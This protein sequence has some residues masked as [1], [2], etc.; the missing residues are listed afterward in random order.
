SEFLVLL[1][2]HAAQRRAGTAE[3]TPAFRCR[4]ARWL[5]FLFASWPLAEVNQKLFNGEAGYW[6]EII[7]H[8]NYDEFWKPR[9]LWRFMNN[10][11][12]A[13]L[14]VGGWFDAEDPMGPFH[15]YR[16]VEKNNPDATNLLVMGP[17]SHGG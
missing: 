14:N 11:K 15:T 12:C 9:S 6:Q 7:D 3:A 8:P 10:V 4:Y 2:I 1:V 17:W 5:R 16:A 13:V